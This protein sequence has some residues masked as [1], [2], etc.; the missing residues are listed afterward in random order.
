MR[1]KLRVAI[2][3]IMT[4]TI[5]GFIIVT[6]TL[7]GFGYYLRDNNCNYA[8]MVNGKKISYTQLEQ[9]VQ[10]TCHHQRELSN[11]RL[12]HLRDNES[13][14]RK[15]VLTCLID[16]ILL[17]EYAD[18]LR[19]TISDD[20]IKKVIVE[21]PSF[22]TERK[23]DNSKFQLILKNLGLS[24]KQYADLIRKKLLTQQVIENIS[25]S[26][27][28]LPE[29]INR[30]LTIPLQ[31]REARL[32]TFHVDSLSEQQTVSNNE[33]EIKYHAN[34]KNYFLPEAFKVIYIPIDFKSIKK[35]ITVDE[36][37]LQVWYDENYKQFIIPSRKRYSIIQTNNENDAYLC[38]KQLKQGANFSDLAKIY[39]TDLVSSKNGGDIGWISHDNHNYEEINQIPLSK[40][41]QM[42]SVV[43]SSVGFLII[44]LDD[45]ESETIYPL[46][47]VYNQV[48]ERVKK[49]KAIHI[50]N[51]L[52]KIVND[53]GRN[54]ND[55]LIFKKISPSLEIN[56]TDWFGYNNVPDILDYDEVKEFIFQKTILGATSEFIT[57]NENLS[58]F[59][60]IIDYRPKCL[61]T[62]ERA[63][64][65]VEQDVKR[66][67]SLIQARLKAEKTLLSLQN[68]EEKTVL[69]ANGITFSAGQQFDFINYDNQLVKAVFSLPIPVNGKSTYCI[70]RNSE[71]DYVIVALDK[72]I[73]RK[74]DENQ[75]KYFMEDLNKKIIHASFNAILESLR[76]EAK[77]TIGY[78][79]IEENEKYEALLQ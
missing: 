22:L 51:E 48:V 49:E 25:N 11:A 40:K 53:T 57:I 47:L 59:I 37:E 50:Y 43:K 73:L 55:L 71:G 9:A 69:K 4:K 26:N 72:V 56:K 62:L 27:F 45:M 7:N 38:L 34:K 66:E 77:I 32:A 78:S 13:D 58:F 54:G 46:R 18:K 12:F 33:I 64:I 39:S 63:R 23:F 67:K 3:C 41:G 1:D 70:T 31:I 65:K 19:L 8:A 5:L 79:L 21:I 29:E 61:Q 42:S 17:E 16:E 76:S 6:L 52:K 28:L 14:I 35:K 10:Q 24:P 68:S 36:R 44:R 2:N 20:R 75:K 30:L 15:K 74:L 60:R